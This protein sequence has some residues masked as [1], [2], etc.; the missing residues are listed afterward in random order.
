MLCIGTEPW[1]GSTAEIE[2]SSPPWGRLT[3]R[4]IQQI[5]PVTTLA[6]QPWPL[7]ACSPSLP[8]ILPSAAKR[9][10][11]MPEVGYE[12]GA[13]GGCLRQEVELAEAERT[14]EASIA[15]LTAISDCDLVPDT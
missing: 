3:A 9:A 12:L 15:A 4:P 7:A 1:S 5:G 14:R 6:S 10:F 11:C 13:N 2:S 8:A